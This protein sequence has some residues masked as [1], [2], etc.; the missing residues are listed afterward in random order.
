MVHLSPE[1]RAAFADL[2]AAVH[3]SEHFD[4]DTFSLVQDLAADKALSVFD[5]LA[6]FPLIAEKTFAHI[7]ATDDKR[8]AEAWFQIGSELSERGFTLAQFRHKAK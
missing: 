5:V 2:A 6:A 1:V 4:A 3:F 7:H 8:A